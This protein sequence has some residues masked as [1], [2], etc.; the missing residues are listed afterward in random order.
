MTEDQKDEV[1]AEQIA[2]R[3]YDLH[4]RHNNL[5]ERFH[6]DPLLED[7]IGIKGEIAFGRKYKLLRYWLGREDRPYGDGGVDYN[8][9]GLGTIGVKTAQKPYY[10]LEKAGKVAAQFY[11]LG[12]YGKNGEVNFIGWAHG[13]DLAKVDPKDIGKRGILS[14]YIHQSKL[15]PMQELI[16]LIEGFQCEKLNKTCGACA[17]HKYVGPN[18]REGFG[19]C[20]FNGKGCFGFRAACKNFIPKEEVNGNSGEVESD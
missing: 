15:N 8:V 10:L 1:A 14:H 16:E 3:W 19:K 2:Q 17:C 7:K 4:V 12:Q 6:E 20:V 9:P 11:P 13:S 5:T 18:P